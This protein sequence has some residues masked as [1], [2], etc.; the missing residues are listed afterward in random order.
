MQEKGRGGA[1]R[2]RRPT[3]RR[4]KDRKPTDRRPTD[5][6]PTT[7]FL[8]FIQLCFHIGSLPMVSVE[9][10]LLRRMPG[11]PITAIFGIGLSYEPRT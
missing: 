3:D 7:I 2:R 10:L 1:C 8:I 4:P 9:V 11:M 6:R 5:K